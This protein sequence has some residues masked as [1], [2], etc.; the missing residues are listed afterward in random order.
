MQ[1][2]SYENEFDLHGNKPVGGTFSGEPR[3]ETEAKGN[4][5]MTYYVALMYGVDFIAPIKTAQSAHEAGN[6]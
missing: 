1:N 5:E 2:F 3:F 6:W 4:S